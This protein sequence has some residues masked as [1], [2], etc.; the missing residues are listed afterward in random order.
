MHVTPFLA[1]VFHN[2]NSSHKQVRLR[3]IFEEVPSERNTFFVHH[4]AAPLW[5]YWNNAI[6]FVSGSLKCGTCSVTTCEYDRER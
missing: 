5:L 6:D 4:G 1:P 3:E 2:S